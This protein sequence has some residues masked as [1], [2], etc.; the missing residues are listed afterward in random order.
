MKV[1]T[2][3][4]LVSSKENQLLTKYI[5]IFAIVIQFRSVKKEKKQAN[6]QDT[7]SGQ[8]ISYGR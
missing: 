1:N 7:K 5:N 6:K 3:R 8:F 4:Q 2:Q